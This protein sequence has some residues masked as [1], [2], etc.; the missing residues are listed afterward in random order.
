MNGVGDF[1]AVAL[2]QFAEVGELALGLSLSQAE[3]GYE[4]DLLRVNKLNSQI[5]GSGFLHGAFRT[6]ASSGGIGAATKATGQ[7]RQQ[8]TVHG[9]SHENG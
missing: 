5:V 7:H 3:A 4:D 6:V 1:H 8:R 9:L 2:E